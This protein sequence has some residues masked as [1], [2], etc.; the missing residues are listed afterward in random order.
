MKKLLSLLVVFTLL[1]GIIPTVSADDVLLISPNPNSLSF[2]DLPQDDW[3]YEAVMSL[4]KD[5]IISGADGLIRPGDFITREEF[6]KVIILATGRV[7]NTGISFEAPDKDEIQPWALLYIATAFE[8]G[9]MKGYEDESVG[10]KNLLTRA[11]VASICVKALKANCEYTGVSFSDVEKDS[12]Y[13][14]DVECAKV[15]GIINGYED[16][17]FRGDN[18]VTRKEAF[19]IIYKTKALLDVLNS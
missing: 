10:P 3:S 12:W 8:D 14:Q 2:A 19:T 17:T 1:L 11:Q 6:A 16:G 4:A 7:P 13:A 15:L 5:G 18:P 9:L